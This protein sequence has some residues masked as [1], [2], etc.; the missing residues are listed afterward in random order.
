[1]LTGILGADVGVRQLRGFVCA[2]ACFGELSCLIG[3]DDVA[4]VD[5]AFCDAALTVSIAAVA[6]GVIVVL[7]FRSISQAD[8]R[9]GI[10]RT[11]LPH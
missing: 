9:A 8:S 2:V 4:G 3:E 1:M 11:V 10:G 5:A 7:T 6:N